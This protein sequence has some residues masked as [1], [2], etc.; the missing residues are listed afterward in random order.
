MVH[1]ALSWAKFFKA[2]WDCNKNNKLPRNHVCS[3]VKV[4][5]MNGF[6][7]LLCQKHLKLFIFFLSNKSLINGIGGL[8]WINYNME[9]LKHCIFEC[10]ILLSQYDTECHKVT[11]EKHFFFSI[12]MKTIHC[13]NYI[14]KVS[15]VVNTISY[16]TLLY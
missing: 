9:N 1:L 12:Y 13:F 6:I 10:I 8:K 16:L 7:F 14:F 3:R 2:W 5:F 11:V 15:Y 4:Y